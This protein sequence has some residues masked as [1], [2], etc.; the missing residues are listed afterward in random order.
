MSLDISLNDVEH[1]LYEDN[2]THNLREMASKVTCFIIQW[3][4]YETKEITLYD[5][6]WRG[7]GQSGLVIAPMLEV[8]LHELKENKEIYEEY[9]PENSWGNYE[10]LVKFTE[11]LLEACKK[12]PETTLW[13]HR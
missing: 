10:G 6:L 11:G 7:S 2:I 5:I 4:N 3:K 1:E 12:Y 8:G 13:C 9:N